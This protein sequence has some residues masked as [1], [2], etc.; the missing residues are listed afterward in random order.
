MQKKQNASITFPVALCGMNNILPAD[1]IGQN[2]ATK[3]YNVTYDETIKKF[4][5]SNIYIKDNNIDDKIIKIYKVSYKNKPTLMFILKNGFILSNNYSNKIEVEGIINDVVSNED[6]IYFS[7]ENKLFQYSNDRLSNINYEEHYLTTNNY[8]SPLDVCNIFYKDGNLYTISA[9]D[10]IDVGIYV[11]PV[12]KLKDDATANRKLIISDRKFSGAQGCRIYNLS[13]TLIFI[14]KSKVTSGNYKNLYEIIGDLYTENSFLEIFEIFHFTD[15]YHGY[16]LDIYT[17][18]SKSK[19]KINF[20][21]SGEKVET[22]NNY[23]KNYSYMNTATYKELLLNNEDEINSYKVIA[24][25]TYNTNYQNNSFDNLKVM[26]GISIYN[27]D[28]S[29]RYVSTEEFD[30][31]IVSV[32]LTGNV[33]LTFICR[34]FEY[35]KQII[36]FFNNFVYYIDLNCDI[37]KR[38]NLQFKKLSINLPDKDY[39]IRDVTQ[40]NETFYLLIQDKNNVKPA[41][42]SAV[43][44][45]LKGYIPKLLIN[46]ARLILCQDKSFLYSGVGNFNNWIIKNDSDS[47]FLEVGY[48]DSGLIKDCIITYGSIIVFK[49]N[50]FIYKVSGDYPNWIVT[51]I[52]ETSKL[53][54]NVINYAGILIFGTETGLKQLSTTQAYGDFIISDFQNNIIANKVINISIN[55]KRK[56]IIFCSK[57]YVFEY[58][59]QLKIF[60]VY[61]TEIYNQMIELDENGINTNYALKNNKLYIEDKTLNNI[62]VERAL[63]HNQYNIVIK[64]ITLYTDTLQEDTEIEIEFYKDKKITRT[65]KAGQSKHKFF[66]TV[67]LKE[68][69]LKYKH[70]G[71]IF[72][73]NTIIELMNIGA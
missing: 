11:Y 46:N 16:Y 70:N 68:L 8:F 59:T 35:E 40:N 33:E 7:I 24:Y 61:Q 50:G 39:Y 54:S 15:M 25:T 31:K 38:D 9:S 48:K 73:N 22:Y 67:M 44:F 36:A 53:T 28:N 42:V 47:L 57:D 14:S 6:G 2:Q 63:I 32:I 64:S 51:K 62:T 45:R 66:I 60:Y 65:L 18:C 23:L 71:S 12:D 3:L 5:G 69:Q 58:H 29:Y 37:S 34:I 49:D 10:V 52:G 21:M 43:S 72:I 55:E 27:D 20:I 1:M 26:L 19:T 4:K 56:T 13:D 41:Y 30:Y 17:T